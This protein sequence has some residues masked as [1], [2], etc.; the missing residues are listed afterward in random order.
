M[1]NPGFKLTVPNQ[2]QMSIIPPSCIISEKREINVDCKKK[3]NT[4]K[5]AE[6]M[7]KKVLFILKQDTIVK[8]V[9]PF[10]YVQMACIMA[11]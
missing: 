7:Y 9:F 4:K 10:V 2:R 11:F 5:A 6:E 3:K 8:Q 1:A